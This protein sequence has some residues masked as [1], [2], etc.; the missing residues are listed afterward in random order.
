MPLSA[1][2]AHFYDGKGRLPANLEELVQAGFI[3]ALPEPPAGKRFVLDPSSMQ[4]LAL[5]Q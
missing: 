1:A 4:V 2:V 3:K 5:P